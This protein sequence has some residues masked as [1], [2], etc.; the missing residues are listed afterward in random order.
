MRSIVLLVLGAAIYFFA[1]CA[2]PDPV[3]AQ[4]VAHHAKVSEAVESV[5]IW[6]ALGSLDTAPEEHVIDGVTA[7]IRQRTATVDDLQAAYDAQ[8]KKRKYLSDLFD[9]QEELRNAANE[10]S[11][12]AQAVRDPEV[13]RA[14]I[15]L[16]TGGQDFLAASDKWGKLQSK[17]GEWNESLFLAF[18]DQTAPPDPT[19]ADQLN[20]ELKETIAAIE[21]LL[22]LRETLFSEYQGVVLRRAAT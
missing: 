13:R 19:V 10:Q 4:L 1:S 14:A 22:V 2:K 16:A 5:Y 7:K 3:P 12:L 18:R 11:R 15:K 17:K 6:G 20:R 9:K 21:R 8:V